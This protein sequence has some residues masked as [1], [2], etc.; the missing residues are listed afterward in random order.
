MPNPLGIILA[1]ATTL[2][3]A[4]PAFAFGSSHSS[5]STASR[6]G[7]AARSVGVTSTRLSPS[8]R[9]QSQAAPTRFSSTTTAK[10]LVLT[11]PGVL[12]KTTT[13]HTTS[14][15]ADP[16]AAD[17]PAPSATT[18]A[19]SPG[20]L[21]GG[22]GSSANLSQF[23]TGALDVAT[24]A[25]SPPLTTDLNSATLP[26]PGANLESAIP[27]VSGL[28]TGASTSTTTVSASIISAENLLL[29]STA[30]SGA[31]AQAPT[32]AAISSAAIIGTQGE[33]IAT[34]GGSS[35]RGGGASG[36]TMQECVAAWDKPTHMTKTLWR[37]VCART[38]ELEP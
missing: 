2:I 9:F 1:A 37:Q 14:T 32:T 6:A 18:A 34:S 15:A 35:L 12:T 26:S 10:M 16:P 3:S 33:V 24:P 8:T 7:T 36:R 28:Q 11:A 19:T 22:Q 5:S 30:T 17:P 23:N 13:A 29:L 38:L 20:T 25:V 27:A 21:G 31:V 4:V